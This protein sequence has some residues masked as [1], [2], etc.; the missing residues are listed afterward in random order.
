MPNIS[1]FNLTTIENTICTGVTAMTLSS[2]TSFYHVLQSSIRA[3]SLA[4]AVTLVSIPIFSESLL[5][6]IHNF[7]HLSLSIALISKGGALLTGGSSAVL[8]IM[9]FWIFFRSFQTLPTQPPEPRMVTRR[10]SFSSSSHRPLFSRS[11]RHTS[12]R[13]RLDDMLDDLLQTIGA[14]LS[15]APSRLRR[16]RQNS[17]QTFDLDFLSHIPSN[18]KVIVDSWLKRLEETRDYIF[19]RQALSKTVLSILESL[20]PSKGYDA[21]RHFFYTFVPE[22]LEACEDRANV[23]LTFVYIHWRI[24]TLAKEKATIQKKMEALVKCAKG[25]AIMDAVE[26]KLRTKPD[27]SESSEIFLLFANRYKGQ[28][29]TPIQRMTNDQY[30]EKELRENFYI[31]DEYIVNTVNKKIFDTLS[32]LRE[33]DEVM[34][35]DPLYKKLHDDLPEIPTESQATDF[36]FAK[37]ELIRK[38]LKDWRIELNLVK[39]R[40]WFS[41]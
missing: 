27:F 11:Q 13:M 19:S 10:E 4:L 26:L 34:M 40:S 20:N 5:P 16:W 39:P 12:N 15:G 38:R 1:L 35:E 7:T 8:P 29:D 32:T 17:T 6:A 14:P 21:F 3:E 28:I 37:A 41:L 30:A 36:Q 24:A 18:E 2:P 9:I 31:S 33:L 25:I 22:N 23:T